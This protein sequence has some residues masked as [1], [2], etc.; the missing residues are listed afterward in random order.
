MTNIVILSQSPYKEI[1]SRL[2][3]L[4]KIVSSLAEKLEKEPP[5]GLR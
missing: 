2:S 1:I 5:Y 3:R 4:E